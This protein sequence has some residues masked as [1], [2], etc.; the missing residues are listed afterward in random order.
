MTSEPVSLVGV[1]DA[2]R[3]LN[4]LDKSLR[5]ELTRDFQD[6]VRPVLIEAKSLAPSEAPLSGMDRSWT[7]K[8]AKNEVLP[9][10]PTPRKA[11]PKPTA[12]E[13]ARSRGA[14][15]QYTTWAKWNAKI[16]AFT[17]GKRPKM[18]QGYMK[19][20][21]TF[22]VKWQGPAAVLF[23]TSAKAHT[24][25]GQQMIS[26]LNSRFGSPSRVMWKAMN[27][28][29]K[30]VTHEVEQLSKRIIREANKALTIQGRINKAR[31]AQ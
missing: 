20:V 1:K 4:K 14:R 3:T 24:K 11:P 17:S 29:G 30:D 27:R 26:A 15:R 23:D 2:L 13:M 31:K 6:I 10:S 19:N 16:I 18:Y 22:G 9:Y 12:E 21:S 28:G 8:G 5:R 7:P 25:Q